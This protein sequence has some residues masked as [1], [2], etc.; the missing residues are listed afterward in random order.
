MN[1]VAR[2]FGHPYLSTGLEIFDLGTDDDAFLNVVLHY[3]AVK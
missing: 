3:V 1:E 2:E